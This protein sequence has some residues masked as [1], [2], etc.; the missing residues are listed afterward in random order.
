MHAKFSVLKKDSLFLFLEGGFVFRQRA[1]LSS[2]LRSVDEK[3]FI[4][5]S[6]SCGE[7]KKGKQKSDDGCAEYK[8]SPALCFSGD[9]VTRC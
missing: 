1:R 9:G 6:M 7:I 5:V 3:V 8:F 4:R 2:A